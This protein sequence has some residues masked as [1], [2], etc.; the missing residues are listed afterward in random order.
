MPTPRSNR[1]RR[2][3]AG[4]RGPGR[5][6]FR[7]LAA[8]ILAAA[9]LFVVQPG[10]AAPTRP[11]K[12]AVFDFALDDRS[13]AGDL[14]KPNAVDTENLRKATQ[15]ARAML[16]ASGRYS[17]VDTGAATKDQAQPCDGC[18]AALARKLGADRSMVGLFTRVSRT[19]YTLQIVIRDAQT[20]AV[21]TDAFSGLRMGAN[22]SWPR[23][24]KWLM[25]HKIL[26][27]Q[28]AQ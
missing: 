19:E 20:G 9:S 22:Y 2:G 18:E 23:G 16:A 1:H 14:F 11:I 26:T 28:N 21:V 24:L 25:D 7:T 15:D 6:G 10:K 5:A 17:L 8:A 27:A 4:F 3:R 13:A 12:I